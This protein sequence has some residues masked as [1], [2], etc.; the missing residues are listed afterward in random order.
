MIGIGGSKTIHLIIGHVPLIAHH[1]W[2]R[3]SS[4]VSFLTIKNWVNR[5]VKFGIWCKHRYPPSPNRTI[6]MIIIFLNFIIY[7]LLY[8]TLNDS[9]SILF[10]NDFELFRFCSR[11]DSLQCKNSVQPIYTHGAFGSC[12]RNNNSFDNNRPTSHIGWSS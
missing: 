11:W 4:I 8:F 5:W 12:R 9:F 3:K 7:G 2:K 1:I 10:I 6:I